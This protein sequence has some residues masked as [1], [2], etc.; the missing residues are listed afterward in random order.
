M[1]VYTI[2]GGK[3]G[4][5]K[6]TTAASLGVALYDAGFDVALVDADLAMAN[7]AELFDV[8]AERGVHHV[9]AGEASVR[10]VLVER[11]EGFY[12]VPGGRSIDLFGDA[13]AANLRDVVAPLAD[14]VDVVLV[15]TGAGLGHETLVAAGLADATLVVSTPAGE[16][17]AD[18]ARTVEFVDHADATVIGAVVTRTGEGTDLGAVAADL[19]VPVL[20]AVPEDDSVGTEPVTTGRAGV[21]YRRL[22]AT[23]LAAEGA[24][25]GDV[26][27][28]ASCY[29]SPS[30]DAGDER[31]ETDQAEAD[32]SGWLSSFAD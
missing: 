9:L 1:G 2:A 7:L 3:G 12:L 32:A 18:V 8:D 14:A 23:L 16:A 11:S 10:D 6:S 26:P 19:A 22:A 24:D 17:R 25:S 5:G 28:P 30:P 29:W 20:S 13:D 21:A 31:A 27:A 15:D 4:V